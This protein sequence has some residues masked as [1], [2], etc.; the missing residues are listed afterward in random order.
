M[1]NSPF[2]NWINQYSRNVSFVFIGYDFNCGL[3]L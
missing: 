1:V 2:M 3:N